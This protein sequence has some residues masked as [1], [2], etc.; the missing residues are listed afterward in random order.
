M[1]QAH[2]NQMRQQ[3]QTATQSQAVPRYGLVTSYD[4][5]N[6]SAKVM[7]QP[8]NVETGWLPVGAEWVGNGW[9]LF[10]PPTPGNM[11]EVQFQEGG[12]SA[13]YICKVFYNDVDRPLPVPSGEFWLVH[14]SGSLLKFDNNGNVELA[15]KQDLIATVG[16]N[17]NVTATGNLNLAVTGNIAS[18]AASWT[19][20]GD[21]SVIGTIRATV[22][23]IAK[24][25]SLLR[26]LHG[27]IIR[28]LDKTDPPQ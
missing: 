19:H 17:A 16:G 9:G 1:M 22:D 27:G 5:N 15:T 20:T 11:A 26:H 10:C 14:Q 23:I 3:A 8:E 4:P 24:T 12:Q 28:G 13:G 2:L 25:I 6:Y 21:F 7:L 18:S